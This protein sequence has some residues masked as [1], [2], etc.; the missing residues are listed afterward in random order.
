M[1]RFTSSFRMVGSLIEITVIRM[2]TTS[3]WA[4][5]SI[6][7]IATGAKG[8]AEKNVALPINAI[9]AIEKRIKTIGTDFDLALTTISFQL[10]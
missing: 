6:V 2:K 5:E 1:R 4:D 9:N 7:T 8:S 10:F 3:A